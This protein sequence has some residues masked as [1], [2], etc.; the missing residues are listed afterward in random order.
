MTE[1]KRQQL[2]GQYKYLLNIKR[3]TNRY[4]QEKPFKDLNREQKLFWK[5]MKNSVSIIAR[6]ASVLRE[7]LYE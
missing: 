3:S 5:Y 1:L 6:H 7:V 4:L 2:E